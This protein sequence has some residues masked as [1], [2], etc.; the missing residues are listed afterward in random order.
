MKN[1]R[2]LGVLFLITILSVNSFCQSLENFDDVLN[3]NK[4]GKLITKR[5]GKDISERILLGILKDDRGAVQYYVVKEFLRVKA[6]IVYRGHSRILFFNSEKKLVFESILSMPYDLP[7][8]LKNDSLYFKYSD[9]GI[10][11]IFKQSVHPLPK[12]ICV[13]PKSCYELSIP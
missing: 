7:F 12:M 6:A 1:I 5:E 13:Q 11:K 8:K 4:T 3:E 10:P 9:N 2:I